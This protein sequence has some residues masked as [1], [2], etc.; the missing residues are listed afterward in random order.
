MRDL[1]KKNVHRDLHCTY[2]NNGMS[3]TKAICAD[4]QKKLHMCMETSDFLLDS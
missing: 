4:V 1:N 2:N 3:K